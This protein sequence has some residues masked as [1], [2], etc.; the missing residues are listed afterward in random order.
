MNLSQRQE[1]NTNT[2]GTEWEHKRGLKP[3]S[4]IQAVKTRISI[5]QGK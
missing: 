3:Y 1:I 2:A 4:Q 5:S